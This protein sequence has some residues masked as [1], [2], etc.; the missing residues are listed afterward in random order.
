MPHFVQ[1]SQTLVCTLS[2]G[3]IVVL[4]WYKCGILSSNLHKQNSSTKLRPLYCY[5]YSSL[6]SRPHGMEMR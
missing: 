6:I 1:K 4:L 2:K 5:M 3:S